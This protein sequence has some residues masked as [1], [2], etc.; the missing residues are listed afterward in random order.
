VDN[1]EKNINQFS[2]ILPVRNGGS[3]VKECINSLLNQT[4]KEYNIIVLDN[5]STDG[6]LEWLRSLQHQQIEIIPAGR[7]LSI[8]ENWS[9]IKD[10]KKNEFI[11]LI[12]HDDL[13]SPT[14][15]ST[16]DTLIKK[17]PTASLYQTHFTYINSTGEKVK[18]CLPM[19]EV[20]DAAAFL[21]C[22]FL[23]T[24]DSTGTG[25]AMRSFDYDRL[26]GIP[27]YPNL[28]FADYE[29]WVRLTGLSFK[30]TSNTVAFQYRLHNSVSKL[31][32]A[33]QYQAAFLQ[34][35]KFLL[36]YKSGK[37]DVNNVIQKNGYR[38]LDFICASLSHRLLQIPKT[39]RNK[40][41]NDF[42]KECIEVSKELLGDKNK[43]NPYRSISILT[44]I[45]I[46]NSRFGSYLFSAYRKW[47]YNRS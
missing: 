29:L 36:E 44:A 6:T 33:I 22:Q 40:S 14:Y 1:L 17:Y 45:L 27:N 30:A 3:Y 2:I 24:L 8:E 38:M 16:I 32:N 21:N 31:T 23:R 15:L 28:I 39:E 10:I 41:V 9:R 37:E 19:A 35:C 12:G 18:D 7:P 46:D 43:F 5:C 11:T 4:Y 42:V 34:Y 20:Q 25:Y 26:G 13:L 47:K